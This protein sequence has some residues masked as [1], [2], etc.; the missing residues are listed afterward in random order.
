MGRQKLTYRQKDKES[1]TNKGR[2]T[3]KLTDGQRDE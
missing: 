1:D 2:Q 3:Y